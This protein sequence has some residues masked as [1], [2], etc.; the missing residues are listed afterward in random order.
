MYWAAAAM[1]C[2]RMPPYKTG[3]SCTPTEKWAE[4]GPAACSTEQAI[5]T[6]VQ[7]TITLTEQAGDRPQPHGSKPSVP[8][9]LH[10]L[11]G[12]PT[13][14]LSF[15]TRALLLRWSSIPVH[16][17]EQAAGPSLFCPPRQEPPVCS[18]TAPFPK[19]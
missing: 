13:A 11:P 3:C 16:Q 10:T 1:I 7:V 15:P 12:A 4:H 19:A 18:G 2:R 14:N 9:G 17:R 8:V 6:A 5:L